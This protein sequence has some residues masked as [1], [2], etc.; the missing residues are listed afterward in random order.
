MG[1]NAGLLS[2]IYNQPSSVRFQTLDF[3]TDADGNP[4]KGVGFDMQIFG[5][6][7]QSV[8]EVAASE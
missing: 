1:V 2:K 5:S 7:M 4:L 8:H 3:E 6:G